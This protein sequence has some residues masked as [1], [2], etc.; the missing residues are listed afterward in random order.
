MKSHQGDKIIWRN[1]FF[2][3]FW[4][5]DEISRQTSNFVT[6]TNTQ[7]WRSK[8]KKSSKCIFYHLDAEFRQL[9]I[10]KN[11]YWTLKIFENKIV[12]CLRG[13]EITGLDGLQRKGGISRCR[14]ICGV[15]RCVF[16]DNVGICE[17]LFVGDF[18]IFFCNFRP[19]PRLL[20]NEAKKIWKTN[21]EISC[22]CTFNMLYTV[23]KSVQYR[24]KWK[25]LQLNTENKK[26]KY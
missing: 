9:L 19:W 5:C 26:N 22:I 20:L 12:F 7:Q 8:W 10:R 14:Q 6:H 3:Q 24:C 25:E 11:H 16:S 23:Y 1:E 21:N 15:K 17:N 13:Y 2:S 4:R 18:K